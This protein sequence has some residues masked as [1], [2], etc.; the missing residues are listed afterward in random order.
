MDLA[1]Y[2]ARVIDSY[3]LVTYIPDPLGSFLDELSR[4][5]IPGCSAHAHVTLLPPRHLNGTVEEAKEVL[6]TE[7]RT[8]SPFE[9]Q[10]T[11]IEIF[12][13]TSVIYA[14]IGLGR[15]RLLEIHKQLNVGALAFHEQFA[16]HPH[17]TLAIDTDHADIYALADRAREHWHEYS[18]SRRFVV[19]ALHF[20]H[21]V[22]MKDWE[23][24]AVYDLVGAA[25]SQ[26][27]V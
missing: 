23:E 26:P 7:S 13:I 11:D 9:L 18:G 12:D 25:H 20:V 27:G 8:I 14:N 19:D 4:S 17:V 10:I 22:G 15:S 1:Q 3:A 16:Y 21:N 2:R 5:L 24:I 6:S